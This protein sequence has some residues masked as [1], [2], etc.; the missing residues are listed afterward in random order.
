MFQVHQNTTR[1]SCLPTG[2]FLVVSDW[3]HNPCLCIF[4]PL[5]TQS[6]LGFF[7]LC[8]LQLSLSLNS[9]IRIV[10]FPRIFPSSLCVTFFLGPSF[11]SPSLGMSH[12]VQNQVSLFVILL[13]F[14]HVHLHHITYFFP[15]FI[16]LC[17]AFFWT[18]SFCKMKACSQK[19]SGYVCWDHLYP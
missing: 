17:I 18:A 4:H 1:P 6:L 5:S 7:F 2:Y 11:H 19:Q 15:F 13:Y 12:F 8:S 10:F 9:C 16:A 3:L 14:Y